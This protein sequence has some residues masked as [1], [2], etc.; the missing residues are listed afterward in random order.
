M[1]RYFKWTGTNNDRMRIY[2][3]VQVAQRSFD[4][5]NYCHSSF[6]IPIRI[7]SDLLP[8]LL[9][10]SIRLALIA[11]LSKYHRLALSSLHSLGMPPSAFHLDQKESTH[12]GAI[13]LLLSSCDP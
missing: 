2:D 8:Q 13:P 3:F 4:D 7:C 10:C 1:T 6:F 12:L 9:F 5:V 11:L